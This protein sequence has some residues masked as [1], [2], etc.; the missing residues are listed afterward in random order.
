VQGA[1][2]IVN[3]IVFDLAEGTI[4]PIMPRILSVLSFS[5]RHERE[6]ELIVNKLKEGR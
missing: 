2:S 5:F 6:Q 4:P 1:S 3:A